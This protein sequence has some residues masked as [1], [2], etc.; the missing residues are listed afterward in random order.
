MVWCGVVWWGVCV[1]GGGVDR[2]GAAWQLANKL[3]TRWLQ[4]REAS[5]GH[6]DRSDSKYGERAAL[7]PREAP[8]MHGWSLCLVRFG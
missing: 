7:P 3:K 4:P 1:G 6:Q 2:T 8:V 5:V